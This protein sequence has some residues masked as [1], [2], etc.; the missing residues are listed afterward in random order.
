MKKIIK[1]KPILFV[2]LFALGFSFL[3]SCKT[4]ERVQKA[5]DPVYYT[6]DYNATFGGHIE[7]KTVQ[8]V[9]E[10]GNS[11]PVIAVA[12]PGY[13]FS[14]WTDTYLDNDE[15]VRIKA[16]VETDVCESH[17]TLAVF[18]KI[19]VKVKYVSGDNGKI[20]GSVIQSTEYGGDTE[21]VTAVPDRGFMFTRWSDGVK[22]PTRNERQLAEN[23]NI[24]AMFD[25]LSRRYTYD[26][27]YAEF[28]CENKEVDLVY[29][30]LDNTTLATPHREHAVFDGWYSDE[31]LTRKVADGN[32]KFLVDDNFL[33]EDCDKLYSKWISLNKEQY[34]ILMVYVTEIKDAK[35][36]KREIFEYVT[37][38]Y[39]MNELEHKVCNLF[40]R[41]I[42][43][44]LNDLAIAEFIVDEYFTKT[45]VTKFT[46]SMTNYKSCNEIFG[47]NLRELD[48]F[49]EK[50]DIIFTAQSLNDFSHEFRNDAGASHIQFPMI[51]MDDMFA[52]QKIEKLLD[53]LSSEWKIYYEV[54]I[55]EIAHSIE[56][57]FT[58]LFDFHEADSYYYHTYKRYLEPHEPVEQYYLNNIIRNGQRLGVPFKY[59][60]RK[61]VKLHYKGDEF[62]YVTYQEPGHY[63][64][65]SYSLETNHDNIQ[66][67]F[68]DGYALP[69]EAKP[70]PGNRFVKW[71]D[72]GTDPVRRDG[73]LTKDF[74]VSAIFEPI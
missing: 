44:K 41:Y 48:E 61:Y 56:A 17:G 7:G 11:E 53:P 31:L 68:Y 52:P 47:N 54:V 18:E 28:N 27:K 32:G 72:G 64:R 36:L 49:R 4:E 57:D 30:Q 62:G 55:H 15:S 21:S 46:T 23:K 25:V 63:G 67:A 14:G 5:E 45:P 20:V 38:N 19:T 6:I 3:I 69:V 2:L 60:E 40:T 8:K 24:T 12:D 29:G 26:Y 59:W 73:C 70:F 37:V 35:A 65:S 74:E 9:V 43:R 10:H 22:E 39:K 50:Y 33:Y 71:S 1:G 51:H 16:R 66:L 13:Y 58:E 34:K 42:S